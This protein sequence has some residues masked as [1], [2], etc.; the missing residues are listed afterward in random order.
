MVQNVERDEIVAHGYFFQRVDIPIANLIICRDGGEGLI[1]VRALP[2]TIVER[3]FKTTHIN[4]TDLF[5]FIVTRFN[6]H[7]LIGINK[8]C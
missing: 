3:A 8:Q 2:G 1:Q 6:T 4:G 5:G 7:F